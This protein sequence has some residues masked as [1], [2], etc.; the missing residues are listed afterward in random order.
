LCVN[1]CTRVLAVLVDFCDRI[2][3]LYVPIQS[4][5]KV[6]AHTGSCLIEN[7]QECST[8]KNSVSKALM[9]HMI[10]YGE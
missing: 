2:S 5:H 8:K 10:I 7:G 6:M 3:T 9:S 4:D 1:G